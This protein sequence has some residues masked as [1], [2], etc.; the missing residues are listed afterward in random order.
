MRTK[1]PLTIV[2][3]KKRNGGYRIIVPKPAGYN[4]IKAYKRTKK[5]LLSLYS[6]YRIK[7]VSYGFYPETNGIKSSYKSNALRHA[8]NRYILTMDIKDYFNHISFKMI[9]Y[10]CTSVYLQMKDI[11]GEYDKGIMDDATKDVSDIRSCLSYYKKNITKYKNAKDIENIINS[12]RYNVNDEKKNYV[13]CY[14]GLPLSPLIAQFAGIAIDRDVL[15]HIPDGITYSRYVDDLTFSSNNKE[16]L[17]GIVDKTKDILKQHGLML[18]ENKT[19]FTDTT[20]KRA[21]ITGLY[22][23][24]DGKVYC[25][26]RYRRKVRAALHNLKSLKSLYALLLKL[27]LDNFYLLCYILLFK[28]RLKYIGTINIWKQNHN[29]TA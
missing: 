5:L 13:I 1:K 18:S 22:V 23:Q 15:L 9:E 24:G 19:K 4:N 10:A 14:Q 28:E 11:L 29:R 2:K 8:N 3:I 17:E 20:I 7:D 25:N 12:K 6:K 16:Q 27:G 21:E 26:R